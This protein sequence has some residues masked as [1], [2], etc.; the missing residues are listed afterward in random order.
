MAPKRKLSDSDAPEVVHPSRQVQ[1]YGDEPKPAKKRKSE[2]A[3]N[4]KQVHT[5]SVNTIKKKIRDVTRKLERAQ[6]LPANVRL[7]DERALAAYQ[8]ELASAEA[9]KIRQ[10]MIKKY[11]MVR[12]FER[13]KATRQL[14]KLR[15]RLLETQSTDEV[16]QLKEEMHI[17]EVDLNYTQYHPLSETYISLYPPKGSEEDGE[18]KI[19]KTKPPMWKEVEKCMEEG[20]LDRLRNRK[21]D[22]T[23]LTKKP[24]KLPERKLMKPKPMPKPKPQEQEQAP[25][26]D[27]TGMNRRQRR[28]QRGV[29]DTRAIKLA[30]NKST[31]FSKNQAFGA[32]EGARADEAQDGNVSDG[33]FFEE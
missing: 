18:A 31:G 30:K 13:Q 22:T 27:T 12:F 6:D 33:G 25:S 32:V 19:N 14:K 3:F 15:K 11:H 28:A 10:K 5:S 9:E 24:I 16:E 1:V 26:I 17:L 21:P 7:E 20:T 2:P 8:Q 4:K 23:I 29:K